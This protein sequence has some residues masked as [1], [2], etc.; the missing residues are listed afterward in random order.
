M[1]ASASE[2]RGQELPRR[3]VEGY[4]QRGRAAGT[5]LLLGERGL[6]KSTLGTVFARAVTCEANRAAPR[7]WFCGTCYACRTIAAGDQPE[8]VVVRPEGKEISIVM[9]REKYSNFS[10]A[11]LH[12]TLLSHRVFVIEEAHWLNEESGNRL[13]KVLEEGPS[14]TMFILISDRPEMLLP[15]IMSRSQ[16]IRL[17]PLPEAVLAEQLR[18]AVPDLG[19]D[20]AAQAARMAAGRWVDGLAL[21]R[22]SEWRAAL[23][24]LAGALE[25]GRGVVQAAARAAEFEFA[26]LWDKEQATAPEVKGDKTIAAARR[27]ELNRQALVTSYDRAAWYLLAR[28]RPPAGLGPQLARLK[29]RIGQNVDV[30]LAQAAFENAL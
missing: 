11:L 9:L 26:P 19:A 21:A 7:L 29:Q 18:A 28:R 27:N 17:R 16:Q 5:F 20:D 8:Y 25:Q 15:T 4:L 24:R 13:L 10:H 2:F 12:P 23:S 1:I 6:G 22:D 3:L 30:N 14:H